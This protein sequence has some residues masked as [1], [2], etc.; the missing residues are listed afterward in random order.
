MPEHRRPTMMDVAAEAGVSQTTV[1][2]VLNGIA[3][4]RVSDETIERVKKAAGALNYSHNARRSIPDERSDTAVIGLIVDEISTDPWMALALEGAREKAV[5][6]GCEIVTFVTNGDAKAEL[7]A[8]RMLSK[9]N[10]SGL[11]YGAIQTRAVTPPPMLLVRPAILLNCY[12]TGRNV[13]SVTPG[14]VVGGRA[15]TQHLI[16][17]G[18]RR[19][20]IIQGEEWMDASRDRLK[21]YRQALASADI[22]FDGSLVR[23]GNW[24][25]S[26]GFEQT[27]ALMALPAPPTAIFC[28]ND[29]M[30]L[31][32]YE[33]LRALGLAVPGDVSVVG[34]DD[35]EIAQFLHPPL[36]T[37][38]LPHFDMG[39]MAVELLLE[40]I[41][42]PGKSPPQLK[43]E[44]PLVERKS[45]GP[46]HDRRPVD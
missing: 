27:L 17:H 33:A 2:L 40:Q 38:L 11:I 3:E 45:V 23:P 34:Y 46:P 43:A 16:D 29:L 21:G 9:L 44:C 15:A 30:A 22:A 36:T 31:G 12:V 4:A 28:S 26:A 18:H 8:A 32:C 14:E 35:R 19:I 6:E 1:S 5:E 25:P 10:L 13:A 20:A 24:E 37:V 42:A 39:A 7:T 41:A